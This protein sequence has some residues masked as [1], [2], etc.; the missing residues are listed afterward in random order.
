MRKEE[1]CAQGQRP[2]R[3]K[4]NPHATETLTNEQDAGRRVKASQETG[5]MTDDS[6]TRKGANIPSYFTAL[7]A[8]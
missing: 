4:K 1:D 3:V 7:C 5:P 8:T 2:C 6:Q